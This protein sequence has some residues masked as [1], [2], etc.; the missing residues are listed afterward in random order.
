MS[1]RQQ[2]VI[3]GAGRREVDAAI[4]QVR[5]ELAAL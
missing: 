1:D 4:A 5:D 2:I 3:A